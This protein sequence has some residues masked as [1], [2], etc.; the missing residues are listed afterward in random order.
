M[1]NQ[2]N[3]RQRRGISA[4]LQTRSI[5]EAARLSGISHRSYTRWL[6]DPVFKAELAGAEGAMI[7]AATR[8]LIGLADG[9][10]DTVEQTRTSTRAMPAIQLRAAQTILD[11]LLKLRELR[12]FEERLEQLEAKVFGEVKDK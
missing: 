3:I 8:R 4:L 9:A 2:L 10:I 5:D 7:D 12:S 6:D 1:I 11:Y